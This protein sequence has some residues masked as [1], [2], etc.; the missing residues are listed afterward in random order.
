MEISG[1]DFK[2]RPISKIEWDFSSNHVQ[3]PGG[4]HRVK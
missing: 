3:Q 1:Y 4:E 2:I